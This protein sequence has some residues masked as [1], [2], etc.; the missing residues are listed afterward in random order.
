MDVGAFT[1]MFSTLCLTQQHNIHVIAVEALPEH[2]KMLRHNL[3]ANQTCF[4][5]GSSFSV[6]C[7]ALGKTSGQCTLHSWEATPAEA[8]LFPEEREHRRL[9]LQQAAIR[10]LLLATDN[11]YE[12]PPTLCERDS[13]M[14][15]LLDKWFMFIDNNESLRQVEHN[16]PT[17]KIKEHEQS[18]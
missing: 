17:P 6:E 16:F 14:L 2:A 13:G 3:S 5:P 7:L 18:V 15:F 4:R 9:R 10:L 12:T 1:G 8:T 11:Q